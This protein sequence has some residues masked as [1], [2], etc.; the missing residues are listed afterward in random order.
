[1]SWLADARSDLAAERILD[2]A[3]ALF[4]ERGVD[5][6]GMDEVARAAGCSRATLYRY[7]ENRNA[8]VHAFAHREARQIT[9]QVARATADLAEPR[10]RIVEAVLAC[11]AAVRERPHLQPWYAGDSTLL[12]EV[13]RDSPL[14]RGTAEAYL[15]DGAEDPDLADWVLRVILSFLTNPGGDESERR[16]L[17]RFLLVPLVR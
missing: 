7:F 9:A 15:A 8:L 1:M 3:G 14:I 2:A 10:R 12:R 17:E 6:P 11:L 5:R 4:V 16:L 13:L